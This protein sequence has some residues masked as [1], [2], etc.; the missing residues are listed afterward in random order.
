MIESGHKLKEESLGKRAQRAGR[1]PHLF[2]A[3]AVNKDFRIAYYKIKHA[4]TLS[5]YD[6]QRQAKA[7]AVT[8]GVASPLVTPNMEESKVTAPLCSL[9]S[10][11]DIYITLTHFFSLNL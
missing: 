1:L 4:L 7:M 2:A 9:S 3:R 5:A 11:I 6:K 8:I 10:H